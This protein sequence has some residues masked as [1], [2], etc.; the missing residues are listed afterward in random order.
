MA[1]ILFF[2]LKEDLLPILEAVERRGPLKYVEIGSFLVDESHSFSHGSELPSLGTSTANSTVSNRSYLVA[3]A[4]VQILTKRWVRNDGSERFFIDQLI[5][6]DTVEFN[7]GGCWGSDIV[8]YGRVA[9]VSDS[10][11]SQELMKAFR[12]AFRKNFTKIKAYWVGPQALILL[13]A[14]KRL[15]IS[16][17]SPSDYDLT[18]V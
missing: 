16:E 17:G 14:G 6:P 12:S 9:T 3:K 4:T 10:G 11:P 8:L 13:K 7:P 1:H 15:T 2:A 5:N 18:M